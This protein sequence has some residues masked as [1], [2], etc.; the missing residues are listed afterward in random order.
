M[1]DGSE[2]VA[3]EPFRLLFVCTGNTCRSPL[4]EAIARRAIAERGWHHVEVR[5]AGAATV[6]GLP[7]SG[8][9]LR[10]AREA[11]LD[12]GG[13]RSTRLDEALVSG[14]D[15]I[16]TMSR[17][18]LDAVRELGGGERVALLA[19]LASGEEGLD[20]GAEVPDPFGRDDDAYRDTLQALDGMIRRVLERLEP[21]L[22]P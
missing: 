19:G 18:H 8:G 16:L 15:L 7:A 17:S 21:I 6:D 22:S 9:S 4:A 11:G 14:A 10:V 13:H 3:S 12:L 20:G 5:S 1:T 2:S